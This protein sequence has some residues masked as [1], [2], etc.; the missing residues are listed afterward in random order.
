[1]ILHHST[2][3]SS[4]LNPFGL[5]PFSGSVQAQAETLAMVSQNAFDTMEVDQFQ[6]FDCFLLSKLPAAEMHQHIPT[7]SQLERVAWIFDRFSG[8][9]NRIEM[10]HI[11]MMLPVCDIIHAYTSERFSVFFYQS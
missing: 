10:F 9:R 5:N 7:F 2:I 3:Q 8:I 11:F 4:I 1:M 6:E